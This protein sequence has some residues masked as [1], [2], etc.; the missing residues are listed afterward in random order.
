MSFAITILGSSS[1]LP[2]SKRFPTA[3]IL[4]VDERFFL[5][6]C[7][8]GTQIQLRRYKIKLGKLNHIFISH[9][10]G[11]HIFGLTGLISSLGLLGRTNDLH[12][13]GNPEL[14]NF[15]QFF[16]T[17]YGEDLPFQIFFHPFGHRR[18]TTIY[19]D[20]KVEVMTIPLKHRIP[21]AGFL[22]REKPKSRN[23]RKDCIEKYTIPIK[24]IVKIKQG[25]DFITDNGI[26]IPNH[27]LTLPPFKRRSYAY[28]S[29]TAY[30]EKIVPLIKNV[31]LLY[32]EATF[33]KSDANLARETYHSTTYEAAKI[34]KMANVKKLIIG[35]FSVRYKKI[36]PLL[37]EAK[38][39]FN[40]TFA[41]N[42][43]DVYSV[44]LEREENSNIP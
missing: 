29:D 6:D 33:K 5:I 11:D 17:Y 18:S 3:Q 40:N 22:F 28:C 25:A 38:E 30:D 16:Q 15:L 7:G 41:V 21:T 32:H 31:D 44:E 10:H 26:S 13:Y 24:D 42:D 36:P 12:I 34:A 9:L 4:N 37:E 27:E 1:A 23:I 39:V 43:G 2:T 8:E 14:Q 19:E 20:D 35:H